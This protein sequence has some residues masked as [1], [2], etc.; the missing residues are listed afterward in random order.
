MT[1]S[2]T[3]TSP[4]PAPRRWT[5]DEYYQM[6]KLGWFRGKRVVLL[7]G[8]IIEMPGQGNAHSVSLGKAESALRQVF[9]EGRY[10]VRTQR[11]LDLPDGVSEPEPDV[12]VVPGT[13]DDYREHPST[14]LLVVE[15]SDSSLLLDRRKAN[16]YAM[17]GVA[18]YW[19]INLPD[20]V[21]EL[22]RDPIADPAVPFG[23]R[24]ARVQTL[25]PGDQ[26]IPVAAPHAQV[27]VADLLPKWAS[28]PQDL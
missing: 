1:R 8:E 24:Y 16:A 27:A 19:I 21:V 25:H 5:R 18:D 9:P 2:A 6:A 3:S 7:D 23:H 11:P 4:A 15:V 17:A 22:H 26:V 20:H 13:P 14:A 28:R 10:W 12:A